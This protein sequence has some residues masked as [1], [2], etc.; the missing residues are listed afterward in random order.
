MTT[1]GSF[2]DTNYGV[3]TTT[4]SRTLVIHSPFLLLFEEL[5]VDD[6]PALLGWVTTDSWLEPIANSAI[7]TLNSCNESMLENT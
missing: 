1:D 5:I 7:S 2:N 4:T 3:K 6:I